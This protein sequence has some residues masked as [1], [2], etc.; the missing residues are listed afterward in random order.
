MGQSKS[1]IAVFA[2]FGVACAEP[3]TVERHD[4][5]PPRLAAMGV[6]DGKARAAIWGGGRV[7]AESPQL[8]WSLDGAFI[9]EGFDVAV[10]GPGTLSLEATLADGRVVDG[11]VTVGTWPGLSMVQQVVDGSGDLSIEGRLGAS[12]PE[13][14][15]GS[16]GTAQ[17]IRLT[18][19]RLDDSHGAMRWMAAAPGMTILELESH[20]ADVLFGTV[21]FE[22][23][24][25]GHVF[26]TLAPATGTVLALSV[27]GAGNNA[28]VWQDVAFGLDGA[29]LTV[30]GHHFAVP[31]EWT[32]EALSELDSPPAHI[33]A[34]LGP[35]LHLTDILEGTHLATD[36]AAHP[37]PDC[38]PADQ[39]FRLHTVFDGRC[40]AAHIDGARVVLELR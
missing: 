3:F 18:T 33:I 37:S 39:S 38:A 28:W 11:D 35:D 29:L 32:N 8:S 10:P 4:L 30:Q 20:T 26:R 34:T 21:E 19:R 14:L 31:P 6:Q 22:D 24:E 2:L 16:A 9:G 23:G 40:S 12:D 5:G 15:V 17:L 1:S 13:P 7:H 36:L 25:P 27:D